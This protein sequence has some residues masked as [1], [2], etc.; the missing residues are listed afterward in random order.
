MA[1]SFSQFITSTSHFV[2]QLLLSVTFVCIAAIVDIGW[3][4][5]A[6]R[7]RPLHPHRNREN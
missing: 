5:V 7:A 6:G 3:M 2:A 4:V 1:G